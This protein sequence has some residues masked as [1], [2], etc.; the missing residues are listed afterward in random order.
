MIDYAKARNITLVFYASPQPPIVW[1]LV[2]KLGLYPYYD[3]WLRTFATMTNFYDFSRLPE[4][5]ANPE[6]YFANDTLHFSLPIGEKILPL[7]LANQCD[8]AH[9]CVTKEN[10]ENNITQRKAELE[11]WLQN[12]AYQEQVIAHLPS[13]IGNG[14]DLPAVFPAIYQPAFK[15]FNVVR[16]LNTEYYAIPETFA[17]PYDFLTI[18]KGEYQGML[19][20]KTLEEITQKITAVKH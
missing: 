3:E 2:S 9:Y 14:L 17:P 10:V 8:D 5:Y 4:I 19:A 12:N 1:A 11:S 16:L 18:M 15:G 6:T 20:G 7:L 13:S